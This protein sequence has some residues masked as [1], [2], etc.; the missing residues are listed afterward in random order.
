MKILLVD[1]EQDIL[2]SLA[3]ALGLFGHTVEKESRAIKALERVKNELFNLVIT[4]V[5]MPDM[6]G[7]HLL[8]RI[9]N[10]NKQIPVIVISAFGDLETVVT[11]I[12]SGVYAY[13][14]KP[15][16][17]HEIM[18]TLKQ[19]EANHEI[20]HTT[21]QNIA[22]GR[23]KTS[24]APDYNVDM[25]ISHMIKRIYDCVKR[26]DGFL[27]LEII[28]RIRSDA[29]K[30]S[31]LFNQGEV[32]L[33]RD[34]TTG[35]YQVLDIIRQILENMEIRLRNKDSTIDTGNLLVLG[36]KVCFEEI[37]ISF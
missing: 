25:E 12:N 17:F 32:D 23:E 37:R 36:D 1:D 34:I 35:A 5:R 6:T 19:L 13:F 24:I 7:I 21:Y 18:E 26:T 30:L 9:K 28:R 10:F 31:D 8:K 15:I 4:D 27:N 11:C 20:E 14:S 22:N 16:R 29:S 33:D 2:D 3:N